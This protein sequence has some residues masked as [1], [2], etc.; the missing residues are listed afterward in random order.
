MLS[1]LIGSI[2][3]AKLMKIANKYNLSYTR[4][5]DDITFSSN[6]DFSK[7]LLEKDD[8]NSWKLKYKFN[9]VIESSGFK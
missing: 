8:D 9:K 1:I 7:L 5:A 2:L 6:R 4:Y 3:D